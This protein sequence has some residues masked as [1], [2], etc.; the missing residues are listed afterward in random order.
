MGMN[1][2]ETV[3]LIAGGHTFG[4]MHGAPRPAQCKGNDAPCPEAKGANANTSGLE[5]PWTR[6]PIAWTHDFLTN[7]Y[8]YEWNLAKGPGGKFQWFP[9]GLDD[10]DRAPDAHDP[11]KSVTTTMLTTDLALRYDPLY[12]PI[13]RRFLDDPKAF[14]DAFARAWFK[15]IHRDLGPKTRY[16]GSD[17]PRE[18]F[19][20]QDP[21]PAV[22]HP[23]VDATDVR[24][25]KKRI[26][27]S[28]LGVSDG[29]KTAWAAAGSFR[30]TDMRGGVNGARLRLEPQR[31]WKV[32]EPEL[33][34]R[35]LA[36]LEGIKDAFNGAQAKAGK[37][38]RISL[39][40]LIVIAGDASVERAARG[41]GIAVEIPFTP[42]R[43]DASQ[44]RTDV[45]S[46]DVMKVTSDGLRNYHDANES[47]LKPL[48][49]FVD[50]ADVLNLTPEEM[51]V[52]T[53]G[54]RVLGANTAG[55]NHRVF[56]RRKEVLTNDFFVN[57][58][59]TSTKWAPST[60]VGGLFVGRD[61]KTGA[62]RWTA[63]PQDLLLGTHPELRTVAFSYASATTKKKF[64]TDFV[65]AW[66]KV[67][68]LD[69]FDLR[70]R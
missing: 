60:T 40:D 4:K 15:L 62:P 39:A 48:R 21:V 52:L 33:L 35:N 42:G 20:W 18:D 67:M 32:N 19:V 31:N 7:L 58:L 65:S 63:T 8:K 13:S 10:A 6:N 70:S 66:T 41:A 22:G 16:L 47:Y 43:T 28:G 49:A 44:E 17:F 30:G 37:A 1:D 64:V 14:G 68:T 50:R 51:V 23:L 55:S 3:A 9:K 5:G 69:R 2:E 38:K 45:A 26:E 46:F 24:A 12:A 34:A 53:G 56:T 57:L 27:S 11:K 29:V 59:D 61:G 25:L 54:L 36:I